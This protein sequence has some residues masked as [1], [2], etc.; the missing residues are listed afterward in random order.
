MYIYIPRYMAAKALEDVEAAR[1]RQEVVVDAAKAAAEK[2]AR[3]AD[4]EATKQSAALAQAAAAFKSLAAAK[5]EEVNPE[6]D[7]PRRNPVKKSR[8]FFGRRGSKAPSRDVSANREPET[9]KRGKS[10]S[11]RESKDKGAKRPSVVEATADVP[12]AKGR[13]IKVL[14]RVLVCYGTRSKRQ[15][16]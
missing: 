12:S 16:G 6:A 11:R 10:V 8:S 1:R 13:K 4:D 15:G 14:S 5:E 3:D 7:E 2:A 9:A